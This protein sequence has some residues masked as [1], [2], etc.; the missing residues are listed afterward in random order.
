MKFC[1]Y[2][3]FWVKKARKKNNLYF[4]Y[5]NLFYNENLVKKNFKYKLINFLY[6][7]SIDFNHVHLKKNNLII[8]SKI[9]SNLSKGGNNFQNSLLIYN[10]FSNIYKIFFNNFSYENFK[11]YK[12][13]KEFFYNFFRYSNYNNFN[14]LINWIFSWSNPM[15]CIECSV[16]PKKYRRK[17]KKKYLYKIKYLNKIKRISKILSWILQYAN[18]LKN[19][20]FLNRIFITYLDLLLNYKNSYLYNKKLLI[21]KKIFKI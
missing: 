14:Y 8:S 21:Y 6:N 19:F 10:V 2:N 16:V 4:L 11:I 3:N 9:I 15:F 17:L 5:Y 20:K 13:S 18:T 12:Y 7:S 1:S